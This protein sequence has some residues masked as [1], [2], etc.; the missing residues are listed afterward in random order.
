MTLEDVLAHSRRFRLP[1]LLVRIVALAPGVLT[2]G[3]GFSPQQGSSFVLMTWGQGSGR[4]ADYSVSGLAQGLGTQLVYGEHAL[5]L[6]VTAVPEPASWALM[7][8][9]VAGLRVWRRR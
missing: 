5:Q 8:V 7:L 3:A 1:P 2:F 4:F 9:G 6:N